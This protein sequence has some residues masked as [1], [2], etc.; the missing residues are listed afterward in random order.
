MQQRL[1]RGLRCLS[2][3]LGVLLQLVK[4]IV[5]PGLA[6]LASRPASNT[7][8]IGTDLQER[9]VKWS[10]CSTPYKALHYRT[11]GD[12]AP[13]KVLCCFRSSSICCGNLRISSQTVLFIKRAWFMAKLHLIFVVKHR[14]WQEY[15]LT[16]NKKSF[17]PSDTTCLFH[18][19]F[20]YI[21]KHSI[22]ALIILVNP[23]PSVGVYYTDKDV[24]DQ[25]RSVCYVCDN[26]S[27]N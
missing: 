19:Y 9:Q 21:I 13:I 10:P 8:S 23:R 16:A 15:A 22:G 14:I 24:S 3:V 1:E 5:R 6:D 20:N 2:C 17:Q 11:V 25:Y 12:V 26:L 18:S 4:L 27:Q 7:T